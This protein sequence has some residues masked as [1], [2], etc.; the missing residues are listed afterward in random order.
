MATIFH[1]RKP[2][3][4]ALKGKENSPAPPGAGG[5]PTRLAACS[6]WRAARGS[7]AVPEFANVSLRA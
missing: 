1:E 3:N 4:G 2:Q 7:A 6:A 5:T